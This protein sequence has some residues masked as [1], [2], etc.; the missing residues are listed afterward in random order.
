MRLAIV[1]LLFLIVSCLAYGS[2]DQQSMPM[3]RAQLQALDI[4]HYVK[5]KEII[6][7][8]T[9]DFDFISLLKEETT[10]FPRGIAFVLPDIDQPIGQQA[11]MTAV[12]DK[13]NNIGW[14][15][16][17][18]TMPSPEIVQ[19]DVNLWQLQ[20]DLINQAQTEPEN[21]PA[22]QNLQLKAGH[23]DDVYSQTYIET[24][25][26]DLTARMQA[27][28][29]QAQ[30]YPGFYLYICQA[31]TCAWLTRLIQQQAITA[32]DALVML[33]AY[34]PQENLNDEFAQQ[35]AKTDFPVLELYRDQDANWVYKQMKTR[36]L[37]ARKNFK[38]NYRQRKL[39]YAF[40]YKA[41]QARTVKEIYGFL[42]A[43]G[44]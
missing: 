6:T 20:Q 16:M 33:S 44:M 22:D 8:S 32:P 40:D 39:F 19:P 35:V 24:I 29:E 41:Q 36:Q 21:P 7:L 11:A 42:T 34:L 26:K 31:K 28:M 18:L 38:T 5:D 1:F 25:E 4:Q 15:T 9:Q 13:L 23:Q 43:V 30:N 2:N 14:T 3:N 10:G 12:Y 37:T 27:A 17:A